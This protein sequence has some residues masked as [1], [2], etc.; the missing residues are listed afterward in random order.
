M[1]LS[2]LVWAVIGSLT[3][4][5]CHYATAGTRM[6]MSADILVGLAGGFLAV[7]LAAMFHW[8]ALDLTWLSAFVCFIGAMVLLVVVR[9][10][11][12]GEMQSRLR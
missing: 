7:M 1:I 8:I 3:G 4:F 12:D 5:I 2:I 9:G 10:V 11:H 6:G